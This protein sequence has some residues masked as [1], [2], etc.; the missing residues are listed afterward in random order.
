MKSDAE[1]FRIRHATEADHEALKLVCLKTGDAGADAADREDDPDLL[2]LIYAVPYQV[3][4]PDFAFVIEDDEG[5][6]G[7]V[8]GA[9]NTKDFAEKYIENWLPPL[10]ARL[11]DPGPDESKWNGSDWARRAIH[12]P[13]ELNHPDLAATP[14]HGHIDL[15]PRAQGRGV[16]R[17]ALEHLM[18]ALGRTGVSGMHLGVAPS[19]ARAIAFYE[20]L[21][22]SRFDST[23]LD[24][25]TVY[26]VRRLDD[27]RD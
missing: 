8:L 13:P 27:M 1:K 9:R 17:K 4:E 5:V 16:G 11:M 15:L 21:G 12:H 24:R 22:F 23:K 19:N 2:G 14:A 7:Y 10:Q 18:R 6:C 20:K 26:M 3:L 25:D